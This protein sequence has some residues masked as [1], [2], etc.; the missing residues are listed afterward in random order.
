MSVPRAAALALALAPWGQAGAAGSDGALLPY[1]VALNVRWGTGAGS[2]AFLQDVGRALAGTLSTTCFARVEIVDDL[3]TADGG[4]L[5]LEVILTDV[6][7]ETIFDDSISN[8]LLPGEPTKELR[9]VARFA[10]S[11][12]AR[13]LLRTGGAEL[14]AKRMRA[15]ISRRPM[16]LGEDPQ[17]TARAQAIDRIVSDLTRALCKK[18]RATEEKIRDAL[19]EAPEVPPP[20]R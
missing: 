12:D 7:D 15:D 19:A 5:F 14:R 4:D 17:V 10:V 11:V 13:L 3:A 9:R 6:W 16:V 18:R 1:P 2:D 8:A 20:L